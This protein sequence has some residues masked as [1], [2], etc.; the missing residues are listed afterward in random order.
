[1]GPLNP[2][3]FIVAGLYILI[4]VPVASFVLV[5]RPSPRA[6]QLAAWGFGLAL[7]FCIGC[8]LFF[9]RLGDD[10]GSSGGLGVALLFSFPGWLFFML[11]RYSLRRVYLD[12]LPPDRRR[13]E[14]LSDAQDAI[15][16]LSQD[17]QKHERRLK[18]WFLSARERR[19]LQAHIL[20]L[21]AALA[22]LEEK[23]AELSK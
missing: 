4:G 14:E 15:E 22:R 6:H 7:L 21:R 9:V 19:E 20:M 12:S 3:D 10:L 16:K 18:S 17:V 8:A 5:L 23:R 13:Y 1:V 2:A 11:W